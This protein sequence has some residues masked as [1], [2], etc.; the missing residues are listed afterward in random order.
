MD[1]L[2]YKKYLNIPKLVVD[3]TGDEFF[4]LDDDH[5]WWN[6]LP[7]NT[8]RLLVGNAEHSMETGILEILSSTVGFYEAILKD[9]ELPK[10]SWS[11]H[12]GSGAILASSN[13]KPSQVILRSATTDPSLTLGK[14]DFRLFRGI[15]PERPCHTLQ[16]DGVCLNPFL[17]TGEDL[18]LA[19]ISADGRYSYIASKPMP[20]Q[21][22][23]TGFFVEMHF[24]GAS[25]NTELIFTT[26]ASIIPDIYPFD[27]PVPG[28]KGNLL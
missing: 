14:R 5:H 18:E 4:L 6:Q 7:G 10:L 2:T 9:F 13:A 21:H 27:P 16:V 3:C 28:T 20:I 15:T 26:Q 23:F 8:W 12:P 25:P 22:A 1:V 19:E 24:P 11:I 17:W